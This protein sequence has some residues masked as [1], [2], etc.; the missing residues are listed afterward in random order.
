MQNASYFDE[1]S[2]VV[3]HAL[4]RLRI[5]VPKLYRSSAE[6][7]RI[8]TALSANENINAAY[9][10]PLTGHV[11]I[12]F[13]SSIPP[14]TII[15]A[16][17][18]PEP[19]KADNNDT[20]HPTRARKKPA[21]SHALP[22][23]RAPKTKP[24]DAVADREIYPAWHMRDADTALAFH[25][26][27]LKTGLASTA[28]EN[29]LR[30]G[31]Y[32]RLP[33]PQ[34]RS[35][36]DILLDQFKSS[37]VLLL[38]I[39]AALSIATG[40]IAEAL[41]II[42]VLALN[43]GIGFVTER[44]AES[45]IAS[46]SELIDDIVPVLRD[47]TFREVQ[48]SHIVAGDV[49][50]LAPGVR[51]AADAR[52]V[53]VNGLTVDES[54]LTGESHFIAKNSAALPRPVPMADRLNMIYMGTAV[55]SGTGLA[56][57]VGTASNTEIGVIQ[58]LMESTEQPKTPLQKHLDQ[59]G[60]RL[61]LISLGACAGVFALGMLRGFGWLQTLKASISLAIAA[62]PEGLPTVATTSLAR[63]IRLMR[64]KQMLVRR[65]QAVETLGAVHTICLDKTG[66]LTMNRM[67]VVQLHTGTR[68]Y[69]LSDGALRW[70]GQ[71]LQADSS[72]ELSRLLQICVLCNENAARNGGGSTAVV[73]GSATENALI[74]LAQKAGISVPEMHEQY[75]LVDAEL[76]AEGRSHMRTV[77]AIAGAD[78]RLVA[79]K[80]SPAEVLGLCESCQADN[81]VLPLTE[82][83]RA[84]L[85]LQNESMAQ[86][87]LRVLGFAYAEPASA[88]E[89]ESEQT[90]ERSGNNGI[91]GKSGN[92]GLIWVGLAGLADPLRAGAEKVIVAFH[93]AGIRTAM[94]TGDQSTT[95]YAIGKSLNL[96]NG[97]EL[98]LVD[99]EHLDQMD[100]D[101]LKKQV[102]QADIFA[103]V[104]PS[105]KLQIVRVLQQTGEVVAMTG[106]GINDGPA[107]QAADVGI[108]MGLRG[109]DLA[110]SA[111]DVVL[112][113][114]QLE[115]ILE[116]IRQGRTITNN[117][118]KSLHFLISSNLSEILVV[119]GAMSAGAP[120]PL[121]PLQLLWL[122]LLSDVLP[123]IALAA[124]PSESDVM[125]QQPRDAAKPLIGKNEL[126]RYA[127]EGS[128]ITA[129]ALASYFYGI[130]RY[131]AGP[132]AGTIAFNSLILGQLLH[133]LSC[134]SDRRG[135]FSGSQSGMN[136]K[137][138]LAIGA[139]IGLQVL[140]NIVPGLRRLLGLGPM[141]ITDIA[142]T[143][144]GAGIPLLLNEAAKPGPAK[145]GPLLH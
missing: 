26:S 29:R 39:S 2:T 82:A 51:V 111:A 76:R 112:K 77:H 136:N 104:S 49:L 70:H 110:R 80:G 99:S 40:G 115:T 3:T 27:S 30:H 132:R 125:Q 22:A 24:R 97:N 140:A 12:L 124:E 129:S 109:T 87:Q 54:A 1:T 121:T 103:R 143:L 56:V 55:A 67:S 79:V 45:T 137:L 9:A 116:A 58:S 42:A 23:V 101:Q 95:A 10:N 85:L 64:E 36:L 72:A 113:D 73:N 106:D 118:E 52:L 28:V 17:G 63:G 13:K 108:A 123:A 78:R 5:A 14:S 16:L 126:K 128:V 89:Q 134:R 6:K 46:L 4:G 114:D 21:S 94:V 53:Q 102:A 139:S 50:I 141:G 57:V 20:A 119:L 96:N 48:A 18:L 92:G 93:Q 25:D 98:H 38:G 8:E 138:N 133:A 69:V 142:V 59:L 74:D 88:S 122:N 65:L 37:P 117:I 60:N 100:P 127:R 47:G 75:T 44:R 105:R 34:T 130:A 91:S 131:G 71:A 145:P 31:G 7:E 68:H 144:A 135:L 120:S 11:L 43:G 15:M 41:A 66:T 90:S 61:V 35:S 33:Q 62:V 32:N 107:L 83:K 84:E 81:Q 19:A 86:Q